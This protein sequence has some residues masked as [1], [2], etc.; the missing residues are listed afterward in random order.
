[1]A[2]GDIVR[3][4]IAIVFLL[5]AVFAVIFVVKNVSGFAF[6]D[7]KLSKAESSEEKT[8]ETIQAKSSGGETE[9]SE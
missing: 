3:V 6:P 9:S 8:P 4:C 2:F 5:L 7:L 1:M